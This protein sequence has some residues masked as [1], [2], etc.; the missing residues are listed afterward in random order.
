MAGARIAR[1]HERSDLRLKRLHG[2]LRQRGMQLIFREQLGAA[3]EIPRQRFDGEIGT[4]SFGSADRIELLLIGKAIELL[5]PVGEQLIENE[6]N[7][8]L[9]ER[10]L[11]FPP[12]AAE[13]HLPGVVIAAE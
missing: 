13:A 10:R 7:A 1:P 12:R 6:R 8:F 3:I 2:R 4:R 11:T 5:G 9:P